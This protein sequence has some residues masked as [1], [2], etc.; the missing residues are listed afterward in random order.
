MKIVSLLSTLY[1]ELVRGVPLYVLLLLGNVLLE[2]FLPGTF[3]PPNILRAF[4][5]FAIFTGA[6][7]AEIVRGG[8]QSLPQ[9]QSEAAQALGLSTFKQTRLIILPQA[10]RNVIPAQV[11]QLIS[12][13]KDTT[14][15]GI[16]M[17]LFDI[18]LVA[19]AI[20]TQDAFK[21]NPP[22]FETL[23]FTA[24]MFWVVAYTVSKESQRFERKLGVAE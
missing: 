4:I 1:I 14:L 8:L 13:F 17:S 12:L 15:A 20:P 18:L 9:G 16:A 23:L 10:L 2:F 6:Y 3:N 24:L 11:G 19:R 5:I 22:L 21:S 7:M